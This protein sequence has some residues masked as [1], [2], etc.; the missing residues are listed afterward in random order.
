MR[1]VRTLN[2][3][4]FRREPPG[5]GWERRRAGGVSLKVARQNW[6]NLPSAGLA[7]YL[8]GCAGT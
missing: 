1:K 8:Q 6:S 2:L 5:L 3:R 7:D 4:E